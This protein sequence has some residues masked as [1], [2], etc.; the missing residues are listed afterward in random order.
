[1][2]EFSLIICLLC[3]FIAAPASADFYGGKADYSQKYAAGRGGEFRL[4]PDTGFI[5]SNSAYAK[6]TKNQGFSG[7]FQ[8]FCVE[9]TETILNNSHIK[10]STTYIDG[11]P[12]SHAYKGGKTVPPYGDN[13]DDRTAYLY[14][15][16]ALGDLEGY[17]YKTDG[18]AG[19]VTFGSK[20]ASFTRNETA[21][22]LQRVIWRLEG[23][24]LAGEDWNTQNSWYN[25]NLEREEE[26]YL[27]DYWYNDLVVP[28]GFGIGNV[29]V[30]QLYENSDYTGHRQ[31]QLYLTPVPGAVLLGILGLGAA[32]MKLRKFA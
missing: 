30:L 25:V 9:V 24:G 22:V 17:V 15:Q 10:V 4:E 1:M 16:F 5:L 8:T 7:S 32:G 23:E 26:R 28:S 20:S 3:L 6:S 21:G 2:K 11:T 18:T 31:D 13:L 12:G 19:S 14:Q 29:R 27:A